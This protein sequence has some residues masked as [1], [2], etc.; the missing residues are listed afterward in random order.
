[1]RKAVTGVRARALA[2]RGNS[3]SEPSSPTSEGALRVEIG[4][5]PRALSAVTV[6]SPVKSSMAQSLG[7][8]CVMSTA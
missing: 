4:M 3:A 8:P 5:A 2:L 7:S 6:A 1:M